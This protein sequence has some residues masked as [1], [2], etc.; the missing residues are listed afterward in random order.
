ML[1]WSLS[2]K[3]HVLSRLFELPCPLNNTIYLNDLHPHRVKLGCGLTWETT[4]VIH[5]HAKEMQ[6]Q[7]VKRFPVR[8]WN[9]FTGKVICCL[10]LMTSY[11]TITG[12]FSILLTQDQLSSVFFFSFWLCKLHKHNQTKQPNKLTRIYQWSQRPVNF[13]AGAF[14]F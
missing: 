8:I 12:Y 3:S 7:K 6:P 13:K 4:P 10:W 14:P 9:L 2:E 1:H 11:N 5:W